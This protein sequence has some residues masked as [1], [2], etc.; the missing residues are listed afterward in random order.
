MVDGI[1]NRLKCV[2]HILLHF[3]CSM[4]ILQC[5]CIHLCIE[6]KKT[7]WLMSIDRHEDMW[8]DECMGGWIDG[9]G[10]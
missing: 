9:F 8:I 2:T 3:L 10:I 1:I 7:E 6:I 4:Y 5:M